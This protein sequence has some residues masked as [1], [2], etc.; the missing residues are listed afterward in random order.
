VLVVVGGE[1][2][3]DEVVVDE[4][5]GEVV[6]AGVEIGDPVPPVPPVPP[7]LPPPP[8]GGVASLPPGLSLVWSC[9]FPTPAPAAS[10]PFFELDPTWRAAPATTSARRA[11]SKT[12]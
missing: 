2:V 1:V 8:A 10:K 3:V 12:Y 7:E 11:T 5:A 9:V 6:P 4:V